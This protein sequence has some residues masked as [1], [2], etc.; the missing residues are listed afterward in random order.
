MPSFAPCFPVQIP[1]FIDLARSQRMM[2]HQ[3]RGNTC[4]PAGKG[5]ENNSASIFR[6]IF[7]TEYHNHNGRVWEIA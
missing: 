1:T 6:V 5:K 7:I 2:T 3:T 4:G